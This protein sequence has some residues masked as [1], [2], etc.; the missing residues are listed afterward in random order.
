M[1]IIVLGTVGVGKSS[2]IKRVVS[3]QFSQKMPTTLGAA[4]FE[5]IYKDNRGLTTVV[6]FWDTAGQ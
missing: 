4:Y 1:K 6:H 3:D 2:L 5:K